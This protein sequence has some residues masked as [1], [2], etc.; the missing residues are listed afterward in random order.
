MNVGRFSVL[1]AAA[2]GLVATGCASRGGNQPPVPFP[3]DP[4]LSKA[5]CLTW[6]PPTYRDVPTVVKCSEGCTEYRPVWRKDV[7]LDEVCRPG[8]VVNVCAPDVC[9]KHQVVQ[10]SPAH[11]E[12]QDVCVPPAPCSCDDPECCYRAVQVPA[13]YR[14]CEK[15][16]T[17]AGI[18]YCYRKPPEYDIV[19]RDVW[20]CVPMAERHPADYRVVWQKECFEEG[21]WAWRERCA[22]CPQPTCQ[23]PVCAPAPCPCPPGSYPQIN[24]ERPVYIQTTPTAVPRRGNFGYAPPP[25]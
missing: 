10:S 23:P 6:I 20:S 1:V 22:P 11:I 2:V 9:R 7:C 19:Q 3:T 15:T 17:E 24:T 5:Y 4:S 25:N 8:A 16:E 21:H 13:Q 14:V 12:W 18:Q